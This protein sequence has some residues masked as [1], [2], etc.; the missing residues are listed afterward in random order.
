MV[1]YVFNSPHLLVQ[2]HQSLNQGS[3]RREETEM[4]SS[5][6]LG[7]SAAPA[8]RRYR[9]CAGGLLLLSIIFLGASSASALPRANLDNCSSNWVN[10][11]GAN[12]CVDQGEQDLSN[13]SVHTHYVACLSDGSLLCC[14][15]TDAGGQDCATI[16][17][18]TLGT[19]GILE[20]LQLSATIGGQQSTT[21]TLSQ[22]QQELKDM[23]VELDDLKTQCGPQL[24]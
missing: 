1:S 12:K 8:M 23:K 18:R 5:T 16:E 3:R 21:S 11:P 7:E 13:N 15:D 22:I 9:A 24:Q 19:R 4:K 20:D 14:V 6:H 17:D 10:N 2:M